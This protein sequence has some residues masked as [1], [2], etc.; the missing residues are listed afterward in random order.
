MCGVITVM[1]LY[2]LEVSDKQPEGANQLLNILQVEWRIHLQKMRNEIDMYL[3]LYA[4]MIVRWR[5]C[6]LFGV[7]NDELNIVRD[8]QGKPYLHNYPDF[9]FNI[10]HTRN[11]LVVAFSLKPV[12]VDIEKIHDADLKIASRFFSEDEQHYINNAIDTDKAFFEIWT[13][14]EAYIKWSGRGL[15]IPLTSFS[16][17]DPRISE[18]LSTIEKSP[19]IISHYNEHDESP[20]II[21]VSEQQLI[22]LAG[23]RFTDFLA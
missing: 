14:K 12:G 15:S 11:A 8:A 10:S 23:K 9:Y 1:Q 7:C 19:Y 4:E 5:A 18:H 3:S 6:C 17:F 13:K 21:T 2:F 16:V 20:Y 22:T